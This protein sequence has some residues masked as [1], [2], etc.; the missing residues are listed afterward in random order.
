MPQP[1]LSIGYLAERTGLAVSAIRYY[2]T[3]GL[4]T[5]WRNA[6]GQ[7]RFERADIRRLSFILIA[8]K[9]GFTLPE[10][11]DQLAT[12]PGKRTPTKADWQKLS[13]AFRGHLDARIAQLETLRDRLD[14]CIGCGCL[15]L[16][17]CKLYNPQDAAAA[18]GQGPRY[19][20]G[21]DAA[22]LGIDPGELRADSD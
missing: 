7:R 11:R 5:P 4:L 10:I 1:G 15:S 21:D 16:D 12:L 17:S 9:F 22:D 20:M 18:L 2:E 19:V 3:Q 13:T 6:G 8:Q 14:G